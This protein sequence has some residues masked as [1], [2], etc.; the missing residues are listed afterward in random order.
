MN[1][2]SNH[3]NKANK[4]IQAIKKGISRKNTSFD[5]LRRRMIKELKA[6]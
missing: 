6:N 1:L 3:P 4:Q 2:F 5:M